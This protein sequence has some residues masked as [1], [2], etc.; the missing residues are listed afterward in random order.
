[1]Q[2]VKVPYQKQGGDKGEALIKYFGQSSFSS[3]MVVTD[4]SLTKVS[5]NVPTKLV[6]ALA[7]GFQTGFA[8]VFEKAPTDQ[9]RSFELFGSAGVPVPATVKTSSRYERSKQTL[10]VTG[11]GGVGLGAIYGGKTLGFGSVIA[12]DLNDDRLELAKE[13][14]ATHTINV[15]G[16]DSAAFAAKVKE[17]S[18]DGRGASLAIEASGAPA[19]MGNAVMALA[20]GGRSVVVGAPP[21]DAP[22]PVPHAHLLVSRHC[23]KCLVVLP[24]PLTNSHATF[25]QAQAT[26]VEGLLMGTS[27]APF[28]PLSHTVTDTLSRT[29][30]YRQLGARGHHPVP[31]GQ[32][33]SGRAAV[34]GQDGQGVQARRH[35]HRGRGPGERQSDQAR[36]CM[37]VA[38]N[39]TLDSCLIRTTFRQ[40]R[41]EQ[42]SLAKKITRKID[43]KNQC[44][45]NT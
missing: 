23:S 31:G 28:D 27:F 7:C 18:A 37:G 44:M 33:R 38:L 36:H 15:R 39:R 21:S 16:L 10:I 14:G 25:G 17:Y 5:S 35:E 6:C 43:P 41:N 34:P 22:L 29:W 42:T 12:C 45:K 4:R 24:H 9:P 1:M 20:V 30:S 32:A 19:A 3:R 40:E 2:H 8:T 11:L 26:S 13:V